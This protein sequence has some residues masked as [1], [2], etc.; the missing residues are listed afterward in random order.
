M[1][2]LLMGLI[3][4][5]ALAGCSG[6][7]IVKTPSNGKNFFSNNSGKKEEWKHKLSKEKLE[8][9]RNDFTFP[10][11]DGEIIYVAVKHKNRVNESN[12][13]EYIKA[14]FEIAW[15]TASIH[16]YLGVFL[17]KPKGE[18]VFLVKYE[19]FFQWQMGLKSNDEFLKEI[20]YQK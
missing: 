12:E 17:N 20:K 2:R 19:D 16:D 9:L 6:S 3:L 11:R 4:I 14:G 8:K 7:K 10:Q 1:K 5:A 13:L 15:E 18:N